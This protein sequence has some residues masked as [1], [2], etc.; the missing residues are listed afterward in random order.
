MSGTEWFWERSRC[1][2]SP[3]LICLDHTA[4][5]AQLKVLESAGIEALHV[6]ILD[7]HFSPS[8]PL[9][10][11]TVQALRKASTLR[12][13]AHVMAVQNDYFIGAL[14][15]IG[16]DQLVFH[17]ETERHVDR[18]LSRI[19][20][21]GARA[22]VALG[23][24]TPLSTLE[25]VLERCDVVL[26]MLISPGYAGNPGERQV[27]YARRKVEALRR[28]IDDR[29][30]PTRIEVDGR[31]SPDMIED[32]GGAGLADVFVAGST[33]LSKDA[34]AQSAAQLAALRMEILRKSGWE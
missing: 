2:L 24:S 15:D 14:L 16:V 28:M 32:L 31:V 18:Q 11:E 21:A 17:L 4:F 29:G 34:L 10:L 20:G 23:P 12:F 8:M 9:G 30:L 5:G 25:Y 19:R 26:L 33:C 13:D 27:P 1:V 22:G 3:S 7:G 6:D